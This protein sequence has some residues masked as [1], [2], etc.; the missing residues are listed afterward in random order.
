MLSLPSKGSIF[1][2]NTCG[3]CKVIRV[4]D[5]DNIDIQFISTGYRKSVRWL[6]LRNGSIKDIFAPSIFNI[7]YLG[8]DLEDH[9]KSTYIR[10]RS[11][12]TRCYSGYPIHYSYEECEVSKRWRCY[13]QFATDIIK[14]E[15]WDNTDFALDK[16]LRVFENKIYGRKYC[17]FVPVEI[18]AF[19]TGVS[20]NSKDSN[21]P[22]GVF[23]NR[24]QFV[25]Q[26][27]I[28]NIPTVLGRFRDPETAAD[29]YK[30][31]KRK[32]ARTLALKY[33]ECI[34]K[35]VFNNLYSYKNQ[36]EF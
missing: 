1:P 7:G 9:D 13:D 26:I 31:A 21:L 27:R 15:H 10:W 22:R 18:N 28:G 12:L 6:S 2:T 11:I 8:C 33:K 34:H 4:I 30:R 25:A 36:F 3:K 29:A 32:H 35:D 17:S 14:M 16:D 19:F 23:R 20:K 5:K 24:G